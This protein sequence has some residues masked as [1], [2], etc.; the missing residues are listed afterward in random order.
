MK[1]VEIFTDGACSGNPGPGGWAALLRY[2]GHEKR[3][4]GS[5]PRTTNNQ[6]ELTAV[7]E[8]LKALKEPC[9]VLLFT[10]SQY[11]QKGITQWIQ[12]WKKNGWKT[13]KKEPV[14]NR[15]LWEE[16]DRLASVHQVEWRWIKGHEGQ[17]ENEICDALAR[18][19]I[20][21]RKAKRFSS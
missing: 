4:S 9:R 18:A 20:P 16:L 12:T 3:L 7:V 19:A 6:M 5:S 11:V 17:R 1:T 8:A 13:S 15:E 2:Q 21:G 10:D 14:K